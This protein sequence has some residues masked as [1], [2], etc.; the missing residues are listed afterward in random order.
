MNDN[1]KPPLH[2][3]PSDEPRAIPPKPGTPA[4]AAQNAIAFWNLM[5][6]AIAELF[7][8]QQGE[9]WRNSWSP[10]DVWRGLVEAS[11]QGGK[12]ARAAMANA[13]AVVRGIGI[14]FGPKKKAKRKA[15]SRDR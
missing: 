10:A 13:D 8:L 2:A 15:R 9:A 1:D 3:V 11:L 12:S 7:A 4:H 5:R 6:P 14:R